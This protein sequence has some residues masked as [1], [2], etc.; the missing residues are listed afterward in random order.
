M[1]VETDGAI[2]FVLTTASHAKRSP[3]PP[4]YV[5][6]IGFGEAMESLWWKKQNYTQLP[7]KT[8]KDTAFKQANIGLK[9][10]DFAHCTIAL[11]RRLFFSLRITVGARKV[12]EQ[13]LQP[14]VT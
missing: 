6:G 14:R 12:K 11:L 3:K 10:I 2:A 13:N 5:L 7:V 1:S 8:A 4:V 9:D